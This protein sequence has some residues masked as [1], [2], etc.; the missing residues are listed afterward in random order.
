MYNEGETI[1]GRLNS[2][3][4][5]DVSPEL[6]WKDRVVEEKDQETFRGQNWSN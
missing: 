5:F 3:A 4:V 1:N 2:Q 6:R